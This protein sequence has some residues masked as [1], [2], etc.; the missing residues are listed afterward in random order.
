MLVADGIYTGEGNRDI[1]FLGKAI[2]VRSEN[3]PESCII[4]CQGSEADP[5]RGLLLP[6]A[7]EPG[8]RIGRLHH[9]KRLQQ[10]GRQLRRWHRQFKTTPAQ[11]SA[12]TSSPVTSV[13]QRRRH[14]PLRQC[15]PADHREPDRRQSGASR[16]AG[17]TVAPTC[18]SHHGQRDQ[19]EQRLILRRGYPDPS[20][21]APFITDNTITNNDAVDGG[22]R[23]SCA[24]RTGG[25]DHRQ[26]DRRQPVRRR[27]V[28]GMAVGGENQSGGRQ[29]DRGQR[30]Q[31]FLG[32]V[33][34][35]TY[36]VDYGVFINNVVARNRAAGA[37]RWGLVQPGLGH[38]DEQH[39]H[40]ERRPGSGRGDGPRQQL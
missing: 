23:A 14:L 37:C 20:S 18:S 22:R 8:I 31:G 34:F 25:L 36:P 26:P 33:S 27:W 13:K 11:L 19:R 21:A 17:S 38:G 35:S 4:D 2:T 28:G 24:G 32:G 16:A 1:D 40:R 30:D 15:R 5:H 6:R 12:T 39:L 3:G 29:R 9:Q 7:R 10:P